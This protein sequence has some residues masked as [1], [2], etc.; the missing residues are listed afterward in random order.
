MR[1]EGLGFIEGR[2]HGPDHLGA[3]SLGGLPLGVPIHQIL[4]PIHRHI[5][6]LIHQ[7][8]KDV[9]Q[10]VRGV[11]QDQQRQS[12]PVHA[13]GVVDPPVEEALLKPFHQPLLLRGVGDRVGGHVEEEEVLLLGGQDALL[14]Q[15]LGNP[16]AD[17]TEL[18]LQLEGIPGFTCKGGDRSESRLSVRRIQKFTL[19]ANFDGSPQQLWTGQPETFPSPL[20]YSLQ[21]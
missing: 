11:G 19:G 3:R 14:H 13:V 8:G 1:Q 2:Q 16:L 18:V 7:V 15:V 12:P 17:V 20:Y 21:S 10:D 9:F 4:G 5:V 6:L